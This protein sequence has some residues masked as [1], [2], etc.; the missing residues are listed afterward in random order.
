MH[1]LIPV[2]HR[3]TKP[4]GV[5]R[6]AA[7]LAECL[8]ASDY[9]SQVTL[10]VGEWQK[11][12]FL[13]SFKLDNEKIELLEISI[14]NTSVSRNQWFMFGLPKLT[15]RIQ[16]NI[17]HMSF[18]F[19]FVRKWFEVPIVSS[20][21]DLYPYEYPQNFGYPQAWFNQ[22]FLLL[23]IQN[24]DGLVCVSNYTLRKLK[25]YFP[26]KVKEQQTEVIYNIVDFSGILPKRPDQLVDGFGSHFL[27]TVAQ[28]RKNKNLNL[29]I[30]AYAKLLKA[31][32][33]QPTTK[34]LMVGSKGPETNNLI[35]LIE[36]L[37]IE[38]SV[39]F[40]SGLKD[41]ELRWLYE[42]ADL[43]VIPSSAEGFC[44]PLV[45]ALSLSCPV[46]CSDIP[47]FREVGSSR[48]AYFKLDRYSPSNLCE[49]I[50]SV[51]SKNSY[52][53]ENID[54]RFTREEVRWQLINLYN[55]FIYQ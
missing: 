53:E 34:L 24:S 21:H 38:E 54:R 30:Q 8:A 2:L 49:A 9:I 17:V 44:L 12:Y 23:S 33:L 32:H 40:L 26:G 10:I 47:I 45:E 42:H 13:H 4:T 36:S 52:N 7:N 14:E 11:S 1:V 39:M 41:G 48:C 35:H 3:P 46:V 29:L 20:I 43:F 55:N 50:L 27:L 31:G 22:L 37:K 16:P 25:Y 5:C 6:H 19:P 15:N 51:V 28:H 18:P